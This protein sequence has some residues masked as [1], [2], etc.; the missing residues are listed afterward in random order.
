MSIAILC[1]AKNSIYKSL[2][3]V[4]VY[5]H[6]RDARTFC[7]S[8]PVICHPPCRSWSAFMS[9]FAKPSKGERDLAYFCAEKTLINGGVLEHPAHSK[10]VNLFKSDKR[11]Q[12]NTIYQEWFGYP[13]RKATW[14]LT[15]AGY[16]LPE[17]PFE[18]KAQHRPGDQK[19]LFEQM[20]HYQRHATTEQFA[21]WLIELVN[22]NR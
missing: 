14:L 15:P 12:I 17:L 3:G 18:L 5:D 16:R 19:H 7:N 21:N 20:S 4:D 2:P 6:E 10:F 9:H 22:V 13:I 11:F 8:N 1:A